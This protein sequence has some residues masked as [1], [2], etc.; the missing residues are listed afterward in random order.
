MMMR[1][2]DDD[3]DEDGDDNKNAKRFTGRQSQFKK[4][5]KF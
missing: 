4:A 1:N 3:N 2:G 5:K